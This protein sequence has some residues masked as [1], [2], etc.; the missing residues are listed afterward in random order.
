M[1]IAIFETV[2][3]IL[4]LSHIPNFSHFFPFFPFLLLG[5][6]LN[7]WWSSSVIK[8]STVSNIV[9]NIYNVFYS[10]Y[11][12]TYNT[13]IVKQNLKITTIKNGTHNKQKV[14]KIVLKK[15]TNK[16]FPRKYELFINTRRN[17]GYSIGL[18]LRWLQYLG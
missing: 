4:F 10:L 8:F 6:C 17:F 15:P 7:K 16:P 14:Y 3:R 1:C 5:K 9:I 12:F 11:R 18:L 13:K 2:L